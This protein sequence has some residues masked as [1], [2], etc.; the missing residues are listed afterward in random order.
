MARTQV[1]TITGRFKKPSG[2]CRAKWG[3]IIQ[4]NQMEDETLENGAIAIINSCP[5]RANYFD[6]FNL[7]VK[8]TLYKNFNPIG[9]HMEM[10]SS[11]V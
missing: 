2:I 8:T 10:N 3:C 11:P 4:C 9:G 1:I 7:L 6:I 5:Q